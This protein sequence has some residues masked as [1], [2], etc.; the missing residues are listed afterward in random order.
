[1]MPP[2]KPVRRIIRRLPSGDCSSDGAQRH[3]GRPNPDVAALNPGYEADFADKD[4]LM[5]G[6]RE[7]I[8]GLGAAS[9]PLLV[10]AQ[11]HTKPTIGWLDVRPGGPLRETVEGFGRG[12]A[13]VGVSAGRD[14]TVEYYTADGNYERLSALA[15]DLVRRSPAA[16]VASSGISAL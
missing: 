5:I 2:T 7:F 12:L 1:M 14:V 10:R 3:P 16:I 13:E 6:R 11:Q 8:A 15:A 9:W 4:L